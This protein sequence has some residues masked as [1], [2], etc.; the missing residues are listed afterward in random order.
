MLLQQLSIAGGFA[1][2]KYTASVLAKY[3]LEY[4]LNNSYS[5][6]GFLS[7]GLFE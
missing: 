4:L 3:Y 1:C 6:L 7:L 5:N 2:F